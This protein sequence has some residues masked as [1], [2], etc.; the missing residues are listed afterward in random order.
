MKFLVVV[1]PPYIY[2]IS[3]NIHPGKTEKT[4]WENDTDNLQDVKKIYCG[5]SSYLWC[6]SHFFTICDHQDTKSD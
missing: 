2:H 6:Y 1:T 5:N 3:T 4:T